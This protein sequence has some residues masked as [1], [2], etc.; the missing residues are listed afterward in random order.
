MYRKMLVDGKVLYFVH[1]PPQTEYDVNPEARRPA[2][3]DPNQP[4]LYNSVYY[5]WWAFLRLNGDYLDCC[6]NGGRGKMS[7]IYKKFGDVRDGQRSSTDPLSSSGEVNEFREW[8]IERGA[9][10]FA[11]PRT[12]QRVLA[13]EEVP[14]DHDMSGRVLLSIPTSGN[15]D[16]TLRAIGGLLRPIFSKR[17]A[18]GHY[19]RAKCKPKDKYQLFSLHQA[20]RIAEAEVRARTAGQ[21]KKLS[22]LV[23]ASGLALNETAIQAN[24]ANVEDVKTRLASRCLKT[25]TKLIANVG[26]GKFPDF[27][28]P[29]PGDFIFHVTRQWSRRTEDDE[30]DISLD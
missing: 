1:A 8:W 15:I 25:A 30:P 23:D 22:A 20:L 19:S 12:T 18:E 4:K 29:Q 3:P 6:A 5:Y 28:D 17:S 7:S 2:P 9:R 11:E 10:L 13:F 24:G 14:Q 27:S 21:K 16:V 26:R